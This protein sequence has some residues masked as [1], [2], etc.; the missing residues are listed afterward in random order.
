MR[1]F[2]LAIL[3]SLFA[4]ACSTPDNIDVNSAEKAFKEAKEYEADERYE[5][6]LKRYD[7]IKNKFPYSQFSKESDLRI[8]DIYFKKEEYVA[9]ALAYSNFKYLYPNH[10][11]IPYVSLQLALSYFNQMPSTID[12]D[13]SKGILAIQEF[14][15]V[16]DKYPGTDFAKTALAKKTA[17]QEMLAQK[18]IYIA[19]FYFKKEH[20]ASALRRYEGLTKMPA[21]DG[22]IA[23]AYKKGAMSAFEAGEVGKGKELLDNLSKKYPSVGTNKDISEIKSKYGIQ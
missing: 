23:E 13:L 6:A 2:I 21:S 3:I 11:S 20:Y 7:E 19:N 15:V 9:A 12:R 16:L 18:E 8:A 1:L 4:T 17:T 5:E 10:T 22:L 14:N